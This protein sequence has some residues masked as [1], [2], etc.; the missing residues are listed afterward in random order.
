[1]IETKETLRRSTTA[2]VVA[3]W[4]R[5]AIFASALNPGERLRQSD[6]A[7]RLGVSTTPVR[8]AFAQLQAEGLLVF[9]PHRSAV[10]FRPTLDDLAETYEI[11]ELLESL[12]VA[13]AIPYFE[14]ATLDNL[15]D[16]LGSMSRER[17]KT[18]WVESNKLFHIGI[19]VP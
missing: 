7:R 2:D 6:I 14:E 3:R 17:D 15:E 19:F 8:E 13:K 16:L 11:R 10:V 4:L 18:R 12:A 1:M 5:E 9:E